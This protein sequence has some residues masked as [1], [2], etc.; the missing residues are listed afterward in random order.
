M[1]LLINEVKEIV[2]RIKMYFAIQ[3]A[4]KE[5]DNAIILAE[6]MY[7]AHNKRFYVLPDMQHKLRVFSWSQIKQMR[8]QGIFSGRAKEPD[9]IH[10]SFYYTPSRLD[11]MYMKPDTKEKKRKSWIEYYKAYRLE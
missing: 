3:K 11:Q 8:A 9:F 5:L 6:E 4:H 7:K 2:S 1:K 10:E